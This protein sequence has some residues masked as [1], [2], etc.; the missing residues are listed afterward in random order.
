MPKPPT[1]Q[2]IIYGHIL[3]LFSHKGLPPK[4]TISMKRHYNA[5]KR[6]EQTQTNAQKSKVND[7]IGPPTVK[8]SKLFKCCIKYKES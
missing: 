3:P 4:Y 6:K 2:F 8:L 5:F 7:E 1:K